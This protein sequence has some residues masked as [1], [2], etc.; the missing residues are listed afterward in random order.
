MKKTKKMK[1]MK[2][3]KLYILLI[4][5]ILFIIVYLV[6]SN[7]NA[8]KS[9]RTLEKDGCCVLQKS[10]YTTTTDIPCS[11]L[12][13]DVLRKLPE[14][15]IFIDYIYTIQNISLSTFHRDVTSSQKIYNTS[16]PVYTLIL[17]KSGGELLSICPG[18]HKTYP[19]VWSTIVNIS[20]DPGT[21]F[22]FDCD[23]LHA[24]CINQCR[25]RDV[26]QY[27][28]CHKD[29]LNKLSHLHGVR[30]HK[31]D[32]CKITARDNI[33]RKLS[34]FFEF[35]INYFLYPVLSNRENTDTITGKI[36]SY[37]ALNFYNK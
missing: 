23:V 28:I 15:Y 34:Y 32:I 21:A 6:E 20:G 8:E 7:E 36:Q 16:H 33:L 27:K 12:M 19:F 11:E 18:S 22:L 2:C 1:K 10:V 26:I 17:Y 4:V 31:T 13:E 30:V 25:K 3:N 37:I 35:P 24:G 14:G 9:T 29:D 5:F